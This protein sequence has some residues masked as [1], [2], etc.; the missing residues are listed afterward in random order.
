MGVDRVTPGTVAVVLDKE[1]N[2]VLLHLRNDK[3]M[4]SLPGGPPDFGESFS[5]A[6]V[7]ETAEETGYKIE[8]IRLIGVYSKSEYWIFDYPDGNRAHAFAAAFEC[9][10]VGGEARPNMEDSLEVRWFPLGEL[11]ENTMPM[12]PKV[13]EDCINGKSGVIS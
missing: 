12:H 13:I 11:P 1:N 4:W 2:L 5:S 8:I 9:V 3:P 10:V 7:R 6:I